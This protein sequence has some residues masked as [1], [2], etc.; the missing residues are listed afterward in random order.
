MGKAS[1]FDESRRCSLPT[2]ARC[3]RAPSQYSVAAAA[4]QSRCAGAHRRTFCCCRHMC[5]QCA[6]RTDEVTAPARTATHLRGRSPLPVCAPPNSPYSRPML[7]W[8]ALQP[9]RRAPMS[10]NILLIQSDSEDANT[11]RDALINGRD[12]ASLVERLG[13]CAT[14]M[15]R[16]A[17]ERTAGNGESGALAAVLLDLSL[18]DSEGI[19]TFDRIFRAAPHI[20]ILILCAAADEGIA[21]TAVQRGAQDYL[22]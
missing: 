21:K 5:V 14:G 9:R 8:K 3:L 22:V 20:P 6:L 12:P 4:G 16:L 2:S 1:D 10:R 19:Q 11:I 18:P 15:Q 13:L 7:Q 17:G